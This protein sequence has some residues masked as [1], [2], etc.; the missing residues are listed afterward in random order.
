MNWGLVHF[1]WIR[2]GSPEI[3]HAEAG[4]WFGLEEVSLKFKPEVMLPSLKFL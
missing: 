2:T 3:S 1:S 4:R